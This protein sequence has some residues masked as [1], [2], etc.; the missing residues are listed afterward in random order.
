MFFRQKRIKNTLQ[1]QL[2]QSYRNEEGQPR[3]RIVVS[4]GKMKLQEE[5]RHTVARCV[6]QSLRGEQNLFRNEITSQEA[7][8]I[9]YIVKIFERT[10][11]AKLN[12]SELKLDG[13]LAG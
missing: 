1:L 6:E 2:V 5:S 13:V 3:Q 9:D 12:D 10:R 8:W 4:L 7:E 11:S